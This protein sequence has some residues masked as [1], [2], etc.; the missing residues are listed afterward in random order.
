MANP[1]ATY[2]FTIAAHLAE[3]DEIVAVLEDLCKKWCFQ[4][5]EGEE[6]GYLHWQGRMSLKVKTRLTTLSKKFV[7]GA[8]LSPT[9][10][11]NMGNDF[12][13]TKEETRVDGPWKDDDAEAE[14]MPYQLEGMKTLYPWQQSIKDLAV[15]RDP[16]TVHMIYD[17]EGNKGKSSFVLAMMWMKLGRKLPFVNDYKDMMRMVMDMPTSNCYFIDI[18]RAIQKDK[19]FQLFAAIEEI[20]G[21]YAYD[22]RYKFREK[23]FHAPQVF[24]FT[25][26]F[27]DTSLLSADRWKFWEIKDLELVP[28]NPTGGTT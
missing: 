7:K 28:L 19:L 12:Y 27:P 23:I 9:Y 3:K 8:H 20:K 10:H 18:P 11:Q 4:K 24:V 13:V 25:N 16:R 5:E 14:E 1:I 17:N 6:T 15:T 21:G 26:R 22:D 2:D